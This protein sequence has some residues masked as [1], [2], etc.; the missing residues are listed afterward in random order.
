[1]RAITEAAQSRL[2]VI[3]GSRDDLQRTHSYEVTPAADAIRRF[4]GDAARGGSAPFSSVPTFVSDGPGHHRHLLSAAERVG[5]GEPLVLDLTACELDARCPAS[6]VKVVVPGLEG[7]S[8]L[9]SALGPRARRVA[10]EE[11]AA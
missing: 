9:P 6:V 2:T 4:A 1:V 8:H 7:S 10:C 3:A 11:E 5:F